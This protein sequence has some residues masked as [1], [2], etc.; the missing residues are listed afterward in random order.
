MDKV[1]PNAGATYQVIRLAPVGFGVV[2]T[3]PD[4]HPTTVTCFATRAAAEGWIANHQKEIAGSN[5]QRRP[6]NRAK[7]DRG[8]R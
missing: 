1:H 4:T 7:R 3:I 5:L 2:V 8:Q 6:I